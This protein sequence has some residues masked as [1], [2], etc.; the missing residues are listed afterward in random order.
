MIRRNLRS[1]SLVLIFSALLTAAPAMARGQNATPTVPTPGATP[2]AS[3]A[4]DQLPDTSVGRQLAWV[5]SAL[6]ER[7]TSLTEAEMVEHFSPDFLAA[8]PA[9]QGI[10]VV[11]EFASLYGPFSFAGFAQPPTDTAALGTIIGR[12]GDAFTVT[13]SVEPTPPHRINGLLFEPGAA[14]AATPVPVS[15]WGELDQRLGALASEVKF[16]AAEINDGTCRPVHALDA[17]REMAIGSAFKLYVLGELAHQVEQGTAAWEEALAIRDDLKSNPG[18]G[19]VNDPAGTTHSLRAYAEQMISISDNTATDHL[20]VRLGRENIETYQAEMG[21][22]DPTR[23]VPF[24]TTRDLFALKLKASPAQLD[25]YLAASPTEKRR[26]LAEAIDPTGLTA[27]DAAGWTSPL[28]ID[29]EWFASADDLC[30]AMT[31]L[32][33]MAERPGLEP[34]RDILAINPGVSF[35]SSVWTYVGFKGGSEPGVLNVT[36][37]LQRADGR[38]FVLTASLN[39]QSRPVDEQDAI[40]LLA[41]VPQLLAATS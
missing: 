10:D 6:N 1:F 33:T 30:R 41:T 7:S 16:L 15:S 37:L 8:V 32:K 22:S 24:L 31:T 5:L 40:D 13:I 11:Q 27:A 28:R 20:I 14:S 38:W 34:V 4:A 3:P 9:S 39:D 35:D 12:A 19:M 21:H 25:A 18:Q 17:E 26:I 23:N 36:W 2:I 29:A